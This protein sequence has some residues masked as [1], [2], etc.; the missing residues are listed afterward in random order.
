MPR[1][2]RGARCATSPNSSSSKA[3]PSS[4][5]TTASSKRSCD[6]Q[7]LFIA[8]QICVAM[9]RISALLAL[10]DGVALFDEGLG[11]LPEV[12]RLRQLDHRF[13]GQLEASGFIRAERVQ[14][15]LAALA[16]GQRRVDG[17][18]FGEGERAIERFTRLAQ[19]VD[20]PELVRALGGDRIA[21]H[22]HLERDV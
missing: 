10:P 18:A 14:R 2:P 12:F 17:D 7:F 3:S 21:G 9:K 20:H 16:H 11:A 8:T 13:A 19:V 6:A 15:E 22:D 1:T 5:T 4:S